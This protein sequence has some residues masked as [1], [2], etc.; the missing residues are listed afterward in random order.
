MRSITLRSR[1]FTRGFFSFTL[2]T[3]LFSAQ[4]AAAHGYMSEPPSRAYACNLGLNA[5]CGP[6]QYEPQSVG[7]SPKGFPAFGPADGQIASGGNSRF[8][9]LDAQSATRWHLT[10]ITDRTIEFNW[11]YTAA[12]KSTKW[13]YFIT[14]PGWN[15][16]LPL[17]RTSFE[18]TPFCTVE[19]GGG[20]PI[21]GHAGGRGPAAKK[22]ACKIPADRSGQHVILGAWTVD[23][24]AFAFYKVV[25]VNITADA[26]S[27][28]DTEKPV[29]PVEPDGWRNVGV[30]APTQALLPGDTVKARAFVGSAESPE[31][32]FGIKIDSMEQ[33]QPANWSLKLAE[34]VNAADKPVRA[35]VRHEDGS[36]EPIQGTNTLFAKPES[37]VTSY[38]MLTTLVPDADAYMH[39]HSMAHEFVLEKGRGSVDLSV[40]TNKSITLEAT[41]YDAA[42][43]Q[44]G[45]SKQMLNATTS[46]L[47][48]AVVSAPGPHSIKLIASTQDGRENFQDFKTFELTGEEASQQYDATFPDGFKTYKAGTTV[49]QP[50]TGKVYE[51]KPFPYS[52]YCVQYSPSASQYEPGVG[53]HW[54]MAWIEK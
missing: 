13:E 4:Q 16:N 43:K 9:A 47:S 10:D 15:P 34:F 29:T 51:C 33:G 1:T 28:I 22:H 11:F 50:K 49:L 30:I 32:S 26:G 8:A 21:D 31:Y 48:V 18:R 37:G 27:S 46:S 14:Q 7:E 6:G 2:L 23:D 24:T 3:A 54:N 38:Q 40:M 20:V 12:H 39:I 52:G 35:G 17:A 53:S 45:F 42:N 25:D 44:V 36:I 5:N 19:G 41:V